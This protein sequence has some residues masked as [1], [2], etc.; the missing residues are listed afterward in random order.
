MQQSGLVRTA[1][2]DAIRHRG[3]ATV[4]PP[5]ASGY[6]AAAVIVVV[7]ACE[8]ASTAIEQRPPGRRA[9]HEKLRHLHALITA[10]YLGLIFASASAVGSSLRCR[11][12]SSRRRQLNTQVLIISPPDRPCVRS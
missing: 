1:I 2:E 4:R 9:L 6:A 7:V 8:C 3:R 12:T 11:E 5:V 10:A